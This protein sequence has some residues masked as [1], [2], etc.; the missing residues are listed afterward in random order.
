MALRTT[1]HSG[2]PTG[3]GTFATDTD[4]MASAAQH[5]RAIAEQMTGRVTRMHAQLESELNAG[6]WQG[7]AQQAYHTLKQELHQAHRELIHALDDM[8]T[9]VHEQ[10]KAYHQQDQ[11]NRAGFTRAAGG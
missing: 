3:G 4:V 2:V 7:P 9:Q 11:D 5:M 1:A 8:T 6:T 10:G